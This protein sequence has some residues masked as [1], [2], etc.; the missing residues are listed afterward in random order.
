MIVEKEFTTKLTISHSH[1]ITEANKN[2][3]MAESTIYDT[4]YRVCKE[5]DG[6]IFREVTLHTG[7][8]GHHKTLRDLLISVAQYEHFRVFIRIEED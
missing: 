8:D 7:I 2:K 4:S 3:I 6:Y 5:P 1:L